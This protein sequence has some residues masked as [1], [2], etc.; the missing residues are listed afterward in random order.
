MEDLLFQFKQDLFKKG[1][2]PSTVHTYLFELNRFSSWLV[3][4]GGDLGK[5]T[6][7]DIQSYL[8]FLQD[9]GISVVTIHKIYA[10]LCTLAKYI[11]RPDI[12]SEIYLPKVFSSLN[13]APK[14]LNKKE[15]SKLLREVERD[16]NLQNI[17]I[18]Y[19]L[20]LTGI[21]VAELVQINRED[22][23][24]GE[25]VGRLTIRNGKGNQVRVVPLA[26][27]IRYHLKRYLEQ[28]FDNHPALFLSNFRQRISVRSVQ[29]M[30]QKYG[31]HPHLLRHTFC[32]QLVA[33]GV[34]IATVADLAG[35]L[36]LNVTRR[37]AKPSEE[38]LQDAINRLSI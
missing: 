13:I 10:S 8:A 32:R 12:V 33:E 23:V 22:M 17:A 34:D 18:T 15:R 28:R 24:M 19:T 27:E 2:M 37:Y 7:F 38:E 6:R 30:M 14:A 1:K 21:R 20:L 16:Q 9:R 29:H 4:S 36:D 26:T 35:H 11:K 25:R 31:V 3:E 5:V